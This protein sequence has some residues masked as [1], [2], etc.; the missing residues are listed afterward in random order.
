MTEGMFKEKS[1]GI[2]NK[3][4]KK[5]FE[6]CN[7]NLG[8]IPTNTFGEIVTRTF[9]EILQNFCKNLYNYV[10]PY[11]YKIKVSL[12]NSLKKRC[13]Y[14]VESLEEFLIHDEIPKGIMEVPEE[15]LNKTTS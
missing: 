9:G 14:F 8:G 10:L 13:D 11:L 15:Y 5:F 3:P 4:K 6:E 1:T 12:R 2:H 7:K